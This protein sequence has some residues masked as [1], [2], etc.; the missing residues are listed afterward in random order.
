[1]IL[2]APMRDI[3]NATTVTVKMATAV[4]SGRAWGAIWKSLTARIPITAGPMPFIAAVV[5]ASFLTRS[6]IGRIGNVMTN[7]GKKIAAAASAAPP[8]PA[9][10]YPTYAATIIIGPG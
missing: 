5:H 6:K 4:G 3:S 2:T 9:I 8:N 7:D 1:M 10:L